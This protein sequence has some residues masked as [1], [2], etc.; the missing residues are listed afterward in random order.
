MPNKPQRPRQSWG[1]RCSRRTKRSVTL[2]SAKSGIWGNKAIAIHQAIAHP[3]E[4][5]HVD[6]KLAQW[7]AAFYETDEFLL[8]KESANIAKYA[9][10]EFITP[11][12]R[13]HDTGLR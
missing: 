8:A 6:I 2:R 5:S 3:L 13:S 4:Q 12:G 10:V 1:W 7:T 11:N 9:V